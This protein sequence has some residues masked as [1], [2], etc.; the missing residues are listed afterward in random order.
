MVEDLTQALGL[1]NR[2][3]VPVEIAL[4]AGALAVPERTLRL[5]GHKDPSEDAVR[6]FRRSAPVCLSFAAAHALAAVRG[7]PKDW[8]ALAS[9]RATELATEPVWKRSPAFSTPALR[10]VIIGTAGANLAMSVGF[11]YRASRRPQ[12][13]LSGAVLRMAL[14]ATWREARA[15]AR[16]GRARVRA[17]AAR[18]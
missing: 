18:A 11:A 12:H 7:T 13:S 1:Q 8:W 2:A 6:M 10:R 15:T 14:R 4:G 5:M 9:L 16:D 3:M 17:V